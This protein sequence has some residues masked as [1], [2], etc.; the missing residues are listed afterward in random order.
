MI[1]HACTVCMLPSEFR[2]MWSCNSTYSCYCLE[3]KLC[4][5]VLHVQTNFDVRG[6]MLF[7][8][9]VCYGTSMQ[10]FVRCPSAPQFTLLTFKCLRRQRGVAWHGM[11]V[12]S[13]T[14]IQ[15]WMPVQSLLTCNLGFR[16]WGTCCH[17]IV[18]E[19]CPST[20]LTL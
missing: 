13:C 19:P 7:S 2:P 16:S 6:C 14:L 18:V 4:L 17:V 1:L 3:Q 5:T 8:C 9:F 12:P 20:S 11:A 15:C 10:S